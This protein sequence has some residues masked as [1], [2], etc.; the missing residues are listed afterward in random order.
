[1]CPLAHTGMSLWQGHTERPADDL[2]PT[3]SEHLTLKSPEFP[4][5]TSSALA[6][7]HAAACAL[8]CPRPPFCAVTPY[9]L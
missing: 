5:A 7:A 6:F 2:T 8:E 4:E 1:M 3:A 9:M